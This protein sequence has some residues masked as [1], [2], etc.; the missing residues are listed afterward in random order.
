MF[1]HKSGRYHSHY[2]NNKTPAPNV[3]ALANTEKFSVVKNTFLEFVGTCYCKWFCHFVCATFVDLA[4]QLLMNDKHKH[5]LQVTCSK[6][7][8]T[9]YQLTH[10]I[11]SQL[12]LLPLTPDWRI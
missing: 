4:L 7:R 5:F 3:W 10:A 6:M 8:E 12:K 11:H 9:P 1:Y 2:G